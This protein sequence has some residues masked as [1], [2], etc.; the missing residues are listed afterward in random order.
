[1]HWNGNLKEK[2]RHSNDLLTGCRYGRNWL[3]AA[4]KNQLSTT[5]SVLGK[6]NIAIT[7]REQ[8]VMLEKQTLQEESD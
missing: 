6:R 8:A 3:P 1:M 4:A 7:Q 2:S 5:A